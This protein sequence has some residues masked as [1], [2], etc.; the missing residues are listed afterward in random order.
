[1][2]LTYKRNTLVRCDIH[3]EATVSSL[4]V[5]PDQESKQNTQ[6]YRSTVRLIS[7]IIVVGVRV[8]HYMRAIISSNTR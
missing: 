8:I 5:V 2:A 7:F 3:M 1:M 4:F 6:H